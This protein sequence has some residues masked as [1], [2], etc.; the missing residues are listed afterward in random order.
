VTPDQQ[1]MF[2]WNLG[3]SENNNQVIIEA[4]NPS[5]QKRIVRSFKVDK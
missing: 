2:L 5:G 4:N 3:L 1:G